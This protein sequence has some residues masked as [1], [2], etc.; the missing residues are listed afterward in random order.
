MSIGLDL[1]ARATAR[2]SAAGRHRA[3]RGRRR[4]ASDATVVLAGLGAGAVAGSAWVLSAPTWSTPGGPV[5]VLGSLTAMVG[6]YLSLVLIVVV[7]R[8][9][10]LERDIGQDRLIALHR[11]LAPWVVGLISAHVVLTTWG[12]AMSAD[13][14]WWTQFTELVL[15]YPWLM[16]AT[17]A[18]VLML[19]IS[20]ASIRRVRSKVHYETWWVGH[21]YLYLSVVLAFGHQLAVGSMFIG[22]EWARIGWIAIY[23]TVAALVLGSRVIL[24]LARTWR[25]RLRVAAVVPESEGVVSIYLVGRNL[26]KLPVKG[27]QFFEWRF[28]TRQWWWQA[29]PY[30]LSA[31]PDGHRLRITVKNLGDQSGAL[32]TLRPG[33]RVLAEGPYGAFTAERARPG[34]PI[35]ALAAGVG[36]APLLSLLGSLPPNRSNVTL[37]Y[38]V[39][40]MAPGTI[41]LQADVEAL[42]A[43][44]GWTLRYL[45]GE[46]DECTMDAVRLSI[47]APDLP[48]A[49]V[50]ACGPRGFLDKAAEATKIAGV[51]AER[52]HDELFVF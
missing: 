31:A 46:I 24:P 29:H 7:A 21:L 13:I 26:H 15:G 34:A 37:I 32:A 40:S 50:F 25:H 5:T 12:Y 18:F 41:A 23:L 27:G 20:A 44:N 2:I 6:T 42:V 9:P 52:F 30:S 45:T 35:V 3:A 39:V 48:R 38:R 51:P 33:T 4:Y 8:V 14:S 17:L 47:L 22:H 19:A 10:W 43:R 36:I 1:P 28:G 16:P 49:D 11:R